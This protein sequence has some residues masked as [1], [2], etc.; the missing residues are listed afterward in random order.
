MDLNYSPADNAF[1]ADIRA[2]LDAN[3]PQA[4]RTKVLDHKRLSRDDY[5]SWH[6]LLG[7]RGWSVVAWPKEFG[8]PGWNATQRH[9]WDEECARI[10]APGVLP[11]GVSMVAP[12]LMK[13][14]S[15][16]QKARYLPRILDGTDWWCQGYSEPGSGSDL[17]SL[18]TR[19]ERQGDHY[20]VNGQKTWTTLGQF[21][22]MMFCL[23]RTDSGAKKQEGISFLLID[24]KT[25]G[26]TVR[27]IITLDEDHE[28]N[29][30]FF[31][32]V[33]VPMENLVG[34][35]NRGWT[36]AKY[37]LGHERT[38]IARVGQSKREL[39][40]LKRL[41]TDQKKGGASL[42]KDPV[43]AAKIA[44]LEIEIMALEVTVQRV[45]ASEANGRGPGPEAS[46][47]K[48]KGTEVQQA[49]TELMVG[50]I[51]PQAAAF[52]PEYLEGERE[53]S[54]AGDDDAAPLAAYYFNFRK[55]SIYG[56]SNEIQKNII[57]QMILGL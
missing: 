19:A 21:A 40:F 18:R 1:R 14:G 55:T 45:V 12:V 5:A 10:G 3:L 42:L 44:A 37:L 38:G 50:A 31:E 36:Y 35:E 23:V 26:I 30:V 53:H 41:A 57:A 29:E 6:K 32:D 48:I 15:D 46:M 34:E 25:P 16:A 11:F 49:L 20:L 52:D 27:P 17:A 22:D 4:L 13:Y 8:G 43:F 7:T 51:G 56:G 24:M 28:V 2:W 54:L 9:I 47:L 33:K 39:V